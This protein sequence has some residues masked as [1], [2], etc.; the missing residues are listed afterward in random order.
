MKIADEA[1]V[2]IDEGWLLQEIAKKFGCCKDMITAAFKYWYSSRD[3]P[4][5]DGRTRRKSLERKS[6]KKKK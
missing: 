1:K 5:P 4:V 6:S 3:L 2:L